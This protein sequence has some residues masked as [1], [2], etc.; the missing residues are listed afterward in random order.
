MLLRLHAV[1]YF[2][3]V[4]GMGGDQGVGARENSAW[5]EY[6]NST[7]KR[8]GRGRNEG[9]LRNSAKHFTIERGIKEGRKK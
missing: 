4:S 5:E 8:V 2:F 1:V 3:I 9:E 7:E 6:G